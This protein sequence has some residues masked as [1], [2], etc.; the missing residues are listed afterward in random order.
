MG[1]QTIAYL[2][3]AVLCIIANGF[4]VLAEF[5]LVK[6]RASRIEELSRSGNRRAVVARELVDQLDSYL[7]ATQL[8]ITVASLGLGWVG[9]PAF[10]D[11][12]ERLIGHPTQFSPGVSHSISAVL[13]F[14]IITFLHILLGELAPK[15][16][17]IRRPE[18]S[19]LW[20]SQPMRW[21][22]RL[23]Y[24]PMLVL[25][26]ASNLVLKLIGLDGDS[27]EASHSAQEIRLLLSTVET[28]KG[29]TLNRLLMLENIFELGRQTVRDAMIRWPNVKTVFLSDSLEELL[30]TVREHSYSRWPVVD[31]LNPV[32]TGYLL[33]RDL[34][35]QAGSDMSWVELIRPLRRVAPTENLEAV[36][37]RLQKDGANMAVVV[38][39]DVPVGLI[40]LED[41]LEE[42]V[43]RIEDEFP[44]LPKVYLKDALAAGNVLLE[45]KA[46]TLEEA[47]R[48]LASSIPPESVPSFSQLCDL[49]GTHLASDVV[50]AAN[51]VA[52]PHLRCPG[53]KRPIIVIGRSTEGIRLRPEVETPTHLFFFVVTPAERP[54]AQS[55]FVEG[56]T[57][58]ARSE[59]IRGRLLI[60]ETPVQV[61]EIIAAADPALTG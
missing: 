46:E 7:A 19:T 20:I 38:E 28:S 39:N 8:G 34:T 31:P 59:V 48:E 14:L 51:G 6:V 33:V 53:A 9:E 36:M 56:M 30:E 27:K 17:A 22:Y 37:Q 23:F 2:L 58:I 32:P 18:A 4:F 35:A 29:F 12:I 52:I 60:A 57:T 21:A 25:N 54:H 49:A 24:V 42:I 10:S 50:D 13:A 3:A 41:I 45:M 15:S 1:F 44:R 55:F 11:L 47:V 43:G 26:G 40:A 61:F 5:A 16:L